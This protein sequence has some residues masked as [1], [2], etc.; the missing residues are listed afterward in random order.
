MQVFWANHITKYCKKQSYFCNFDTQIASVQGVKYLTIFTDSTVHLTLVSVDM[1]SS[2]MTFGRL[3]RLPE[4]QQGNSSCCHR[5]FLFDRALTHCCN[6]CLRPV[7]H[8]LYALWCHL[9]VVTVELLIW[10]TGSWHVQVQ[11]T[12]NF[13]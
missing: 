1:T 13:D 11:D 2:E 4:I 12:K 3:D 7:P 5:C 8:L 9:E 6:K 10:P